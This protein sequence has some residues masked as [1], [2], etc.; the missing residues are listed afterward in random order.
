MRKCQRNVSE[1]K[2]KGTERGSRREEEQEEG[3]QEGG[4][5]AR[6]AFGRVFTSLGFRFKSI[7]SFLTFML[8]LHVSRCCHVAARCCHVAA[9]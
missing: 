9:S 5:V 8:L 3:R 6:P 7:F 1:T 2:D 4:R